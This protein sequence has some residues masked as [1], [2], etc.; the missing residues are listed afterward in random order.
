MPQTLEH[1]EEIKLQDFTIFE[2]SK[3]DINW[4]IIYNC[5]DIAEI[6]DI[7]CNGKI[8]GAYA[9][10]KALPEADYLIVAYQNNQLSG[11]VIAN[12]N[13]YVG[14]LYID[15]I[16]SNKRGL[17]EILMDMSEKY[18][19]KKNLFGTKLSALSHVIGF[20]RSL[21]FKNTKNC[22]IE[23]PTIKQA[24]DTLALPFI[25]QWKSNTD[26][27]LKDDDE[28][29]NNYKKFLLFLINSKLAADENCTTPDE[30]AGL[31][32]SMTKCK[33]EIQYQSGAGR[34]KKQSLPPL[35]SS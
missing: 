28:L 32:Y 16:C 1:E 31:G 2:S 21:G 10:Q 22:F 13:K 23:T 27:H 26:K 3:N 12:T 7:I 5:L 8:K 34:K 29:A 35:F 33:E 30:C 18:V 4:Q 14:F 17:G 11:F 19:S 9:T 24:Y 6:Y 25:T 20:Y 15:I